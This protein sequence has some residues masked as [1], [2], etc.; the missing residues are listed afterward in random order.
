MV[1]GMDGLDRVTDQ[2]L[3]QMVATIVAVAHPERVVLFGS[4]ARGEARD[5][6]DVDLIVIQPLPFDETRSRRAEAARV[7]AALAH[8]RVPKDILLY[9]RD[10]VDRL[11]A[12]RSHV[13]ARALEEG[14]VMYERR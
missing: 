10:E 14:T 1:T 13:L 5:D 2:M 6:S 12:S 7:Y 11:R 8:Y 3:R 9:S 4:W